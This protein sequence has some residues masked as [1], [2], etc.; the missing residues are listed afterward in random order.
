MITYAELQSN[1]RKFSALTGLTLPEFRLLLPAFARSYEQ[2]YSPDRT[3]AGRPRRRS[4][5]GGRRGALHPPEQKLLFLLVYLRTYPLQVIMGELFG[6]SQPAVNSWI[7]RLLPVLRAALD[8]L[9]VLPERDPQGFAQSQPPNPK[10]IID[11]TERRRQRP[12]DPE[13][14]EAHYSGKKKAHSDKNVVIT[15]LEGEGIDFL[16]RTYVGKTHDKKIADQEDISYPPTATLY[17]DT[18]F[19]GYE[20]AVA[21]T[22][23][24]KKKA[25]PRRAH[26]G[27]ETNQPE[28]SEPSG[29]SR[30]CPR[31][32]ETVP[33]R[34]GCLSEH[35]GGSFR[36]GHGNGLW[37]AQ[38][39]GPKPQETTEK[40][41]APYF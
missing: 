28:V 19:Q 10:L 31:G 27:G 21:E 24:A 39:S 9:G 36:L 38:P 12:K 40:L 16:S 1:R 6:L 5:G 33:H 2:L 13:K 32:R 15:S 22:C 8:D 37:V 34:E 29:P 26:D 35:Q 14:Q 3:A 4:A 23:Q 30:A 20:P 11:G 41:T 7:H 17:K 18:G 25:A